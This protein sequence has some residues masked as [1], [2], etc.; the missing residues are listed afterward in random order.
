MAWKRDGQAYN[1]NNMENQ[2]NASNTLVKLDNME[3]VEVICNS[4]NKLG[5]K[6]PA[7]QSEAFCIVAYLD[8][9]EVKTSE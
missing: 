2:T 7:I 6:I 5:N 4:N 3:K 9:S 1:V 8:S